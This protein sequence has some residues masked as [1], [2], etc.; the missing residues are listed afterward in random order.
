M[1]GLIL[2]PRSLAVVTGKVLSARL[3][4]QRGEAVAAAI[5]AG[6]SVV[7]VITAAIIIPQYGVVGAAIAVGVAFVG[8]AF[9]T[10]VVL[11]LWIKTPRVS[12]RP[13]GEEVD[14]L[15]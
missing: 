10:A 11:G 13:I 5:S 7:A 4:N 15:V 1:L 9:V 3:V 12:H 6:T 14:E 2:A 8:H